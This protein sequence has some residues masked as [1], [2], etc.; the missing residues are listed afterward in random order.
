MTSLTSLL[1]MTS[2]SDLTWLIIKQWRCKITF[3]SRWLIYIVSANIVNDK[4]N[5]KII[6]NYL[7]N[8]WHIYILWNG[9]IYQ[10]FETL[11][12]SHIAMLLFNCDMTSIRLFLNY[13]YY[14]ECHMCVISQYV[15]IG[16]VYSCPNFQKSYSNLSTKVLNV[17]LFT[18]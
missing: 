8:Y 11:I 9:R 14:C 15:S 2:L 18:L 4:Y 12:Q 16:L 3:L 17:F 6:Q 13:V 1:K 7:Q 5:L 10:H